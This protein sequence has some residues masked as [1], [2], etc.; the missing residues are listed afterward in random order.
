MEL[1]E[2][3]ISGKTGEPDEN[4]IILHKWQRRKQR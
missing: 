2:L 1:E 3:E 4:Q